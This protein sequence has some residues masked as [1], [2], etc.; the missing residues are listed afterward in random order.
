MPLLRRLGTSALLCTVGVLS[1]PAPALSQAAATATDAGRQPLR[2]GQHDFDFELGTWKIHLKRLLHPLTGSTTW[3]DVDGT[4]ATRKVWDGRAQLNEFEADGSTG[5][6]EGLT[7]RLYNPQTHLWSLTWANAKNGI[8]VVPQIGQ[9]KD[10]RGEF[11]AQD[12]LTGSPVFSETGRDAKSR[13]MLSIFSMIS[14]SMSPI[15]SFGMW[16]EALIIGS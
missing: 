7:L 6:I 3:V 15:A 14:A 13:R 10:G 8:L 4:T 12:T 2:D 9:F 5:H 11:F 16:I 1:H